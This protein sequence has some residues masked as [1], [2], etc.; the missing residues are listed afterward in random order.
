MRSAYKKR[1]PG[2]YVLYL[3]LPKGNPHPFSYAMQSQLF[4]HFAQVET[5]FY[6]GEGLQKCNVKGHTM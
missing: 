4:V 5:C 3:Y 2:G 6:M 1:G